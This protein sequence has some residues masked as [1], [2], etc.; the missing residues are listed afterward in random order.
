MLAG[1]ARLGFSKPTEVQARCLRPGINQRKDLVGAAETGSG[2]TLA[3][4]LPIL[5]HTLAEVDITTGG[6][7]SA[8]SDQ[9]SSTSL[10][11]LRALAVLPTRELAVQVKAHLNAVAQCTAIRT[12]CVVGGMSVEKQKRLLRRMP[13]IV[14][15]TPG[16]L[17][18]LLGLGKEPHLERCDWFRDGLR[19][20]RHLV[21]DEADRLVESGHFKELDRVLDLVYSSLER[22]QQ[23]Q[24]FVFSATLTFDPKSAYHRSKDGEGDGGKVGALMR[25]MHFRETRAV[26][27]VDLTN[28]E[29][30]EM[31]QI[32]VSTRLPAQLVLREAVCKDEKDKEAHLAMWLLRRYRWDVD[33]AITI[34]GGTDKNTNNV[35][36]K[37][38]TGG[39]VAVFVNAITSAMRLTSVLALLLES[40]SSARVLSRVQ[41]TKSND[42]R[43]AL[44][45]ISVDV[46]GLHSKMRQK[47][48][49]KRMERFRHLEHAVLICTD[50]AARGLDVPNIAAVIHYQAPRGAEVFLH[51]SGRT[52]RAGRAGESV[53]FMGPGDAAQYRRIYRAAGVGQTQILDIYTS[54]PELVAA[55]EAIQ[56]ASELE[57]KVHRA[58]K[59]EHDNNWMHRT[60]D[61]A[62]LILEEDE[63]KDAARAAAPRHALF[64]LY[65]QL[66]ARVRRPPRRLGGGPLARRHRR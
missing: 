63:D 52:A 29:P 31:E 4:G 54:S 28:M 46:L 25:R 19:E 65:R 64:G 47:E 38:A 57:G 30:E 33:A 55:R 26:H 59:E 23:L 12:E 43:S 37:S 17:F 3:F 40:P 41:M 44:D 61:E 56:L 53:T 58:A 66:Q 7:Q 45:M 16:R 32:R 36:A 8:T 14:V 50:I 39:R 13:E 22:A 51:R 6:E 62:E 49:L 20:L 27:L 60:A 9:S 11:K 35:A 24:T 21:L 48:R 10:R 2:K 1:L 15:G 34:P 42:P 18:A 5:Q